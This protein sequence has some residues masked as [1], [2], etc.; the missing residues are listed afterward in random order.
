MDQ[1]ILL[2]FPFPQMFTKGVQTA[3][4]SDMLLSLSVFLIL[5]FDVI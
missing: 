4:A 1:L 3:S 5:S 2:S